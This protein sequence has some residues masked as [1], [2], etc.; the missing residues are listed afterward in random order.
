MDNNSCVI[1]KMVYAKMDCTSFIC[2]EGERVH[3]D[4]QSFMHF[5]TSILPEN[6][7]ILQGTILYEFVQ[8]EP[9]KNI[10][11]LEKEAS[12]KLHP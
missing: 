1:A 9:Y 4:L 8:C 7:T 6:V 10:Q 5:T 2:F 12:M 11:F 3:C